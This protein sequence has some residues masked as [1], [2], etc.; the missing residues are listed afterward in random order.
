MGYDVPVG[1]LTLGPFVGGR[2][3]RIRTESFT[4]RDAGALNLRVDGTS[5]TSVAG[6]VG[7]RLGGTFTVGAGAGTTTVA[8]HVRLAYEHEF[9]HDVR[10]IT[11]SLSGSSL[12]AEPGVGARDAL[13]AGVAV[14]VQVSDQLSLV[15]DY[16]GTLVRADGRD[17]SLLGKV[18]VRF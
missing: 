17:H 12:T 11:A 16:A 1:T 5:A 4:E 3:A 13:V 14:R 9:S 6:A 2:Y 18:E 7:L 15:A 10:R 8:P